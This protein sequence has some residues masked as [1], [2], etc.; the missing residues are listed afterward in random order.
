[1]IK[2]LSDEHKN[3]SFIPQHHVNFILALSTWRHKDL[4]FKVD[5]SCLVGLR[6]VWTM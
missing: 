5:L 1:M 4:K 2:Y 3:L 6:P